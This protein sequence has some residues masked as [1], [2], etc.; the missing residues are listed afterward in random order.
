MIHIV[1]ECL[2]IFLLCLA[3]VCLTSVMYLVCVIATA[4]VNYLRAAAEHHR[5]HAKFYRVF[6]GRDQ[7]QPQ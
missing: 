5:A 7:G 2:A 1:H 6:D 4:T 3:S